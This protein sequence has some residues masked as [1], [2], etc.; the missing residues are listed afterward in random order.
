[1]ITH[2]HFFKSNSTVLLSF[3]ALAKNPVFKQQTTG[4]FGKY[5]TLPQNDEEENVEILLK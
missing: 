2:V 4:F 3:R 1:M 5:K